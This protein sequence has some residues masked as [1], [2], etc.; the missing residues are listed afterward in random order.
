MSARCTCS[1]VPCTLAPAGDD[2]SPKFS[3]QDLKYIVDFGNLP[4]L[5]WMPIDMISEPKS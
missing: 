2:Y 1:A 3:N 4:D 5:D